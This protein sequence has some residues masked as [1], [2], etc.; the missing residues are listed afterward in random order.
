MEISGIYRRP[1]DKTSNATCALILLI[2]AAVDHGV[3]FFDTAKLCGTLTN[4]ELLDSHPD[5]KTSTSPAVDNA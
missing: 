4:K 5:Q 3:T 2:R 1:R